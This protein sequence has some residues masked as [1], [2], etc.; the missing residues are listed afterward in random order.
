MLQLKSIHKNY[1]NQ[2][3]L[4]NINLTIND[5]DFVT[6][7]GPS[8]GGKSTLLYILSLLEAPTMGKIY[9]DNKEINFKKQKNLENIRQ[10][11]IGLVFQNSNLIPALTPLENLLLAINSNESAKEKINR[12][13]DLLKKVG[14]LDKRNSKISSLSGGEAQRISI[15]RAIVNNPKIIF[16]DEPTGALDSKNRDKIIELLVEVRKKLACSLVIVTHDKNLGELGNRQFFL[17]DGVL[18]ELN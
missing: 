12:C 7:M 2:N 11:N 16:C 14:L 3:I 15:V 18:N 13:E 8:G 1:K 17:E 6:I 5:G 10:D 9:F 4:K